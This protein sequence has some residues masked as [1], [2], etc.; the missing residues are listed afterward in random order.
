MSSPAEHCSSVPLRCSDGDLDGVCNGDCTVFQGLILRL[1]P[2]HHFLIQAQRCWILLIY[3]EKEHRETEISLDEPMTARVKSTSK[4]RWFR[5]FP[6]FVLPSTVICICLHF[7]SLP[8]FSTLMILISPPSNFTEVRC[9]K[10]FANRCK[11]L[12]IVFLQDV[13]PAK[14]VCCV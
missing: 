3:F 13:F 8:F 2:F 11:A 4:L 1:I 10:G 12:R 7:Q 6:C 14:R 9:C 5:E